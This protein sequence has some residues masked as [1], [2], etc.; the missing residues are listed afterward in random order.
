MSATGLPSFAVRLRS[1]RVQKDLDA[2]REPDYH[3]VLAVLRTLAAQPRPAGCEKLYDDV[4][5]VR[6]GDWR[7]IYLVDEE[8][9]RVEVGG[10]RR[11]SERTYKGLEDLFG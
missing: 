5:R 9:R 2:L 1:R 4:H 7:I 10:I 8:R 6:I 3:R 11:R